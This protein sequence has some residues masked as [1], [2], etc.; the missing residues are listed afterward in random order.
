[1]VEFQLSS[2][3]FQLTPY[4]SV[5]SA[6]QISAIDSENVGS[7]FDF[8][9]NPFQAHRPPQRSTPILSTFV[10]SLEKL[11]IRFWTTVPIPSDLAAKVISLYLETDHPLLGTFDPGLFVNDLINCETRYCSPFLL[12]TIMY[13]GCV[14]RLSYPYQHPSR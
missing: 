1:V 9:S 2:F 10:E 3:Q 13:W 6:G 7:P 11:D 12:S 8:E 14:G 4:R 5:L